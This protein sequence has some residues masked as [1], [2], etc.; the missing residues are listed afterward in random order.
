MVQVSRMH[1]TTKERKCLTTIIEE[2]MEQLSLGIEIKSPTTVS[3]WTKKGHGLIH[4]VIK[5][6]MFLLR[7]AG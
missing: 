7:L 2:K 3:G 5:R 6:K 1:T 4:G